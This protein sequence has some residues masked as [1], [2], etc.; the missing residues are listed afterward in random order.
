MILGSI[1]LIIYPVTKSYRFAA[2]MAAKAND[3]KNSKKLDE[4]ISSPE[5]FHQFLLFSTSEFVSESPLFWQ[6]SYL[7]SLS[8]LMLFFAHFDDAM[9]AFIAHQ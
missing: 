2:M 9:V 5:G 4:I 7:V 1:P 3:I 6:V 8:T